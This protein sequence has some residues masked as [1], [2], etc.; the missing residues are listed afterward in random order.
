[1]GIIEILKRCI[2]AGAV[3]QDDSDP[4]YAMG[5]LSKIDALSHVVSFRRMKDISEVY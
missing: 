2:C 5:S 3:L 1:M 4:E